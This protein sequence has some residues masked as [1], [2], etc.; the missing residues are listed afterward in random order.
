MKVNDITLVKTC[1][2]CPEQYD[3]KNKDGNTIGYLRLR[4]GE[5]TVQCP[6][7]GGDTV[8]FA[9]PNGDGMFDYDERDEYLSLAKSAI[10]EYWN[11]KCKEKQRFLRDL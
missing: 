6:D 10:T 9:H 2:F 8:F 11:R 1:D 7:N 5:F 3:A 4:W